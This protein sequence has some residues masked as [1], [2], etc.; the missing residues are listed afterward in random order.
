L[1]HVERLL[2][3]MTVLTRSPLMLYLHSHIALVVINAASASHDRSA[4]ALI[5]GLS[6]RQKA[7]GKDAYMIHVGFPLSNTYQRKWRVDLSVDL[8]H[9]DPLRPS[10]HRYAKSENLVRREGR[11]LCH[12]EEPSGDLWTTGHRCRGC[13]DGILSW[14]QDVYRRPSHYLYVVDSR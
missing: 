10:V 11:R 9:V 8:W 14:S 3:S 4:K 12:G 6:Q 7:T 13:R 5:E 1:T 2:L